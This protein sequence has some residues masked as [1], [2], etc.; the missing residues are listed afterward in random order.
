MAKTVLEEIGETKVLPVTD[1]EVVKGGGIVAIVN[2]ALME[3]E[4]AISKL[5]YDVLKSRVK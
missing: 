5:G 1:T 3:I 2:A 4:N